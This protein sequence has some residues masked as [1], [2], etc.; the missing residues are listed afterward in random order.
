M[1][2]KMYVFVGPSGV[3]KDTIANRVMDHYKNFRYSVSVTTRAQ[4]QGE[5]EGKD[6][7][8]I[9]KEAFDKLIE[10]EGLIQYC[11]VHG[12]YYGTLKDDISNIQEGDGVPV[13]IVDVFGFDQIMDLYPYAKGIFIDPPSAK[14]LERR[15]RS[16]GT[17]ADEVIE[18]RLVAAKSG[19][20]KIFRS[21]IL[22]KSN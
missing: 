21:A 6:Y 16:R 9:T 20:K 2:E 8:F 14:E 11:L 15:L 22:S 5:I 4:R 1:S 19:D 18:K 3:G 13:L 17:D 12:N 7:Y 10:E